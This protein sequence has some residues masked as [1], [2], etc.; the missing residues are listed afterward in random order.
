MNHL[1]DL[2]PFWLTIP[3]VLGSFLWRVGRPFTFSHL[4]RLEWS[5][6]FVVTF[7]C[8]GTILFFWY[9]PWLGVART[10]RAGLY[11]PVVATVLSGLVVVWAAI[12]RYQRE[13]ARPP[14]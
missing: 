7:I 1:F 8:A 13:K 5:V 4:S 9:E 10:Q 2:W 11:A 3:L 12:I 14:A 6:L